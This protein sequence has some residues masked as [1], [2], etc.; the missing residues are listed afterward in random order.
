MA[1]D[2]LWKFLVSSFTAMLNSL[3]TSFKW[4]VA[5]PRI[6]AAP[7]PPTPPRDRDLTD[8][9]ILDVLQAVHNLRNQLMVMRLAANDILEDT[10]NGR[11][12]AGINCSNLSTGG[13]AD[14]RAVAR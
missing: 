13:G 3:K 9:E 5:A 11:A 1:A 12:K 6:K 4:P 7:V 10:Q 2:R 8:M 14:Q